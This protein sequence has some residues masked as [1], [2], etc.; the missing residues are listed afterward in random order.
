MRIIHTSFE[1]QENQPQNKIPN[2]MEIGNHAHSGCVIFTIHTAGAPQLSNILG[3]G[4]IH[5][6]LEKF[7]ASNK[8]DF[9][10]PAIGMLRSVAN[11][12]FFCCQLFSCTVG[13][14]C[15]FF[16][17]SSYFCKL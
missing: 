15:L 4:E 11:V 12:T 1:Y 8:L 5:T 7:S 6:A 13:L 16:R 14:F 2:F 17:F 10:H 9:V 3:G